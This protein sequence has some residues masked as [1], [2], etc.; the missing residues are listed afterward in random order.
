MRLDPALGG[1]GTTILCALLNDTGSDLQTVFDTDLATLLGTT[2]VYNGYGT[3]T[4]ITT[5]SG[6]VHR[7][8]IAIHVKLV[9]ANGEEFSEWIEEVGVITS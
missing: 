1:D 6:V 3:V 2:Q 9:H 8:T 4:A 7:Q 5:A